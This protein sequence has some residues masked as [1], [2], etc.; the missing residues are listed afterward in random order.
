M[1]SLGVAYETFKPDVEHTDAV[2]PMS[3][4]SEA[5]AVT[6]ATSAEGGRKLLATTTID[7]LMLYTAAAAAALGG[8]NAAIDKITSAV[9]MSNQIYANSQIDVRLNLVKVA[10]VSA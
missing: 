1:K 8:T 7:V 4:G 5:P 9:G 2:V 3:S 6:N 10:L